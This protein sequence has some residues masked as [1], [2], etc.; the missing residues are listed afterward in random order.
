MRKIRQNSG[1]KIHLS[2]DKEDGVAISRAR[3]HCFQLVSQLTPLGQAISFVFVPGCCLVRVDVRNYTV[4]LLRAA[5]WYLILL[6]LATRRI[7]IDNNIIIKKIKNKKI[8][9][10]IINNSVNNNI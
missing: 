4:H 3:G 10:N 8:I 6:F 1:Q 5:M 2:E 7:I 9:I